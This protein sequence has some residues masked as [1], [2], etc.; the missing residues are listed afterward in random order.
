[1]NLFVGGSAPVIS[2]P[3]AT[4]GNALFMENDTAMFDVTVGT[5]CQFQANI[6]SRTV[7]NL[8]NHVTPSLNSA[9]SLVDSIDGRGL[10]FANGSIPAFSDEPWGNTSGGINSV[11]GSVALNGSNQGLVALNNFDPSQDWSISLWLKVLS[12]PPDWATI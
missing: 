8:D 12:Q 5:G 7:F 4:C 9:S 11:F 1:V 3:A 2:V 10:L 6:D